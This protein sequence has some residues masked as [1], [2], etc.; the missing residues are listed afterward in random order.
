MLRSRVREA[1]Q[2]AGMQQR[3]LAAR[4]GLS[5]QGLGAIES[6]EASPSTTVALELARVLGCRV[7]DL[8]SLPSS[9]TLTAL[10]PEPTGARVRL[11]EVGGRWV[12]HPMP[13]DPVIPADGLAA[14][15]PRAGRVAIRPLREV[16]ALREN[17]LV[18]G[19]DPALGLLA[20]HLIDSPARLRLHW[21]D[22]ASEPALEL[23]A[24]GRVHVAGLHL[25]D[26][27]S[28]E[29]NLPA[30]RGRFGDRPML[31]V[32]LAWWQQGLVAR[33]DRPVRR[34]DDLAAR[35]V[36]VAL[37]EPGSGARALL[38]RLLAA[39]G[40]PRLRSAGTFGGHHAVAR[41]VA[42]GVAD[43]GIA[44]AAAAEAAGLAFVPLADDRFD[45]VMPA[46]LANTPPGARLLDTLAGARFRRDAG[47]L[48]GYRTRGTG[49]IVGRIAA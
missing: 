20:G 19:C 27:A 23:L 11:G 47:A 42:A 5:R 15:P 25:L 4:A 13:S 7:E 45:L 26:E 34:I 32:N 17:L 31:V 29:H 33:R 48:P 21:I 49:T 43:A 10:A 38:D 2:R 9:A 6:G 30:V 41:A 24:A 18:A 22:A 39:A 1:R 16:E 46:E 44:T 37:R 28:G 3:E 36:R 14:R 35:G 8:F 40:I 12:A